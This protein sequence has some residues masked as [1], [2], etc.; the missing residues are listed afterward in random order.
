M[1][2]GPVEDR[3]HLLVAAM[4]SGDYDTVIF[5]DSDKKA[6]RMDSIL[7]RPEWHETLISDNKPWLSIFVRRK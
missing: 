7:L 2:G 6:A 3:R 5:P 1:L 4:E